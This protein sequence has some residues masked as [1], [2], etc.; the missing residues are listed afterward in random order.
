MKKQFYIIVVTSFLILSCSAAYHF[1]IYLPKKYVDTLKKEC[2]V[3]AA[4]K[5]KKE[6][7]EL[8]DQ[9]DITTFNATFAYDVKD[10]RCL[11]KTI[12]FST[13][14]NGDSHYYTWSYEISDIYKNIQFYF[15][16]KIENENRENTFGNKNSFEIAEKKFFL[17]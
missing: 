14:K 6:Q 12:I 16:S 7:Q 3:F 11:Y 2:Y 4:N 13:L 5:Y 17:Q 9:E 8:K 10:S 15:Y 1:I